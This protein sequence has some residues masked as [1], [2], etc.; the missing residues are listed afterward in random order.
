MNKREFI[1]TTVLSSLALTFLPKLTIKG[2]ELNAI[3]SDVKT[4]E[5]SP[6]EYAFDALEP[7]I[8]AKTM[9]IH[10]TKHHAA[11]TNNLNS[12]LKDNHINESNIENI[13]SNVS[14]YPIGV[15]NNGGGY[16]NHELFWKIIKPGGST[17]PFGEIQQAIESNFGSYDSFKQQFTQKA[18][19]VFGSGWTWLIKTDKGLSITNTANQ[20]CPIMDVVTERG[21]PIIM[22]DVWEHAY[23][24]KYQNRRKEYIDA[25]WNIVNWDVAFANYASI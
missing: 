7:Y 17:S 13:L 25:F 19:S 22:I 15:R 10:Y 6:L 4:F 2:R 5:Q 18:M 11:Y 8:D 12:L 9:E 20:D 21:K 1:R 3:P 16:F 24:L 14:K 23:Y